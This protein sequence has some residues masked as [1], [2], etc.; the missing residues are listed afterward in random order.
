MD[1]VYTEIQIANNTKI[2]HI[3]VSFT[4][5]FNAISSQKLKLVKFKGTLIILFYVIPSSSQVPWICF[6]YQNTKKA[7]F[8]KW[9]VGITNSCIKENA[10][11][12]YKNSTS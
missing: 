8:K 9:L 4:D 2:N 3:M 12:F 6:V 1:R 11:R 5:H 10:R 7:F